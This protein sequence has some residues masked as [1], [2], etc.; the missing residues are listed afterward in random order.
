MLTRL[1]ML[2]TTPHSYACVTAGVHVVRG[3]SIDEGVLDLV[4]LKTAKIC[5]AFGDKQAENVSLAYKIA[6]YLDDLQKAS[7][8]PPN[9][10]RLH[11]RTFARSHVCISCRFAATTDMKRVHDDTWY[12]ASRQSV[13]P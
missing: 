9:Q 5:F 4:S 13:H 2:Q 12:Q 8:I 3:V 1:Q 6:T 11:A 10:A 7:G